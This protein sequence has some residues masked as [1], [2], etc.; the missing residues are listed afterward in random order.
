MRKLVFIGLL[1]AGVLGSS[2]FARPS[3]KGSKNLRALSEWM[4]GQFHSK[5][6]HKRDTLIAPIELRQE[7]IWENLVTDGIW[8]YA[9]LRDARSQS[10]IGQKFIKLSDLDDKQMEMT[11]YTVSNIKDY[12]GELSK[13]KPFSS[14]KPDELTLVEDCAV[15][16]VRKTEQKFQG[17][18][19]GTDCKS[20]SR[21]ASYIIQD[22]QVFENK[23][24]WLENGFDSDNKIIWGPLNGGYQFKRDTTKKMK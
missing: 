4:S 13:E 20:G 15:I 22:Y 8:I 5:D 12:E 18:T 2:A 21:R 1:L 3:S 6:H 7:V 19:A 23:V 17:T 11:T 9:E 14:L 24:V 16:F 10:V